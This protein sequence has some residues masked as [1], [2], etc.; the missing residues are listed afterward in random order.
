MRPGFLAGI[1]TQ[2]AIILMYSSNP[3]HKSDQPSGN[4]S[5]NISKS[6]ST[7]GHLFPVFKTFESKSDFSSSINSLNAD[8]FGVPQLHNLQRVATSIIRDW[9]FIF[10]ITKSIFWSNSNSPD[11]GYTGF[12]CRKP[13][14][15][16]FKKFFDS[17]SSDCYLETQCIAPD[18]K[19]LQRT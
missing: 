16:L 7:Q 13:L 17:C 5:T 18:T 15:N 2:T 1:R 12:K 9:A 19:T 10:T 14:I 6:T 8:P 4:S 11:I 3:S